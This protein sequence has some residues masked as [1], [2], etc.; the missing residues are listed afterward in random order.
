MNFKRR[1]KEGIDLNLTPLIDVV[2][3]LLIFFMV[4]TTFDKE[5]QLKIELPQASGE[6]KHAE[7]AIEVSID[8]ASHFYVNQQELVNNNLE[9]IKKVLKQAAGD[10]QSPIIMINADGQAAHQAVI[11]ILDAAS[12]L[13]FVNITFAANKSASLD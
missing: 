2:F 11:K 8:A 7:K 12:Q 3:I 4:T 10:Q 5:T 13:G 9:T 6:Q 1:E